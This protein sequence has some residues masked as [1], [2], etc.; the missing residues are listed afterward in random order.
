MRKLSRCLPL[1][2]LFVSVS[3]TTLPSPEMSVRD[4]GGDEATGAGALELLR[5]SSQRSGDPWQKLERVEVRYEGEWSKFA[6]MTQPVLVDAGYRKTSL[7]I[8]VPSRGL[9]QQEHRGPAGEKLVHRE[10]GKIEVSR[11]GMQ[12]TGEEELQAAALVAD[13]Y[14]LFTFGSS[15]LRERGSGWRVIGQRRLGGERCFLLS[16]ELQPGLGFSERDAVIAWIG[17]ETARLRRIQF[18]LNGL[19]STAG[20]D[21]DVT[22]KDYQPDPDG[23]GTEW[24]RRFVERIR[25]PLDVKAHEWR[26]TD[27]KMNP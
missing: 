8:Y 10:L 26:M 19:A 21:V 22:F 3:C 20:A 12:V 27:L 24:P 16:G 14:V 18:S 15:V 13:A 17:E 1:L 4:P 23:F 25:R 2:L 5:L 6:E 7:E 11:D 9:V